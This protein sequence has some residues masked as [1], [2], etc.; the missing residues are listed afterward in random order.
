MNLRSPTLA[1]AAACAAA[2]G[3]DDDAPDAGACAC[4]A[5][6]PPL[7]GRIVQRSRVIPISAMEGS[8]RGGGIGTSP[9][10]A[11]E[12]VLGGGCLLNE[13]PTALMTLAES[14]FIDNG[15]RCIWMS[16][17]TQAHTG[18]AT[19]ICLTPPP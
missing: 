9:C 13:L 6:E 4:P 12:V 11:G 2:C 14:G 7:A 19:A 5:A 18:T 10:L 17:S 15:V 16:T 1:L 8:Q 3:A